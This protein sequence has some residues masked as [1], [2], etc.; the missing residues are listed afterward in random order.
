MGFDVLSFNLEIS[1]AVELGFVIACGVRITN[2]ASTPLSFKTIWVALDIRFDLASPNTSTGLACDHDAG[3]FSLSKRSVS[4]ESLARHP[5]N[6]IS[7]SVAMTPGPP[8][9]V[10]IPRFAPFGIFFLPIN[11][12]QSNISPI[13]FTLAKPTRLKAAS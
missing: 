12:A 10:I 8:A 6:S 1:L 13:S 2:M 9:L 3:R 4:S 11:S 7:L 5:F